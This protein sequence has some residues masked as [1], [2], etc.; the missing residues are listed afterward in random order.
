M[1]LVVLFVFHRLSVRHGMRGEVESSPPRGFR[2][3]YTTH[4]EADAAA[5]A[6]AEEEGV[7]TRSSERR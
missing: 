1:G 2:T 3:V 4:T 5:V 7:H 6:A